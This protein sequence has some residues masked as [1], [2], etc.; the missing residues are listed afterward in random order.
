MKWLIDC[1]FYPI[2][3][4]LIEHGDYQTSATQY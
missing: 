3:S 4:G 1:R 2:R